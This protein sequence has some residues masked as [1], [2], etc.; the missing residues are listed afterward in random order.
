MVNENLDFDPEAV[1]LRPSNWRNTA[2]EPI[3]RTEL[4]LM[5]GMDHSNDPAAGDTAEGADA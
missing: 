1:P 4:D 3:D 5:D 2:G